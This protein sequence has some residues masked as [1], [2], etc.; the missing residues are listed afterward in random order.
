MCRN[1]TH[2]TFYFKNLENCDTGCE[3]IWKVPFEVTIKAMVS[4][5]DTNWVARTSLLAS[6]LVV[7]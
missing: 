4:I 6:G 7:W 5:E 2:D 3:L 1:M